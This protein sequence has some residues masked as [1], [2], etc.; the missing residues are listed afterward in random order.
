MKRIFTT[1]AFVLS[2]MVAFSQ[3]YIIPSVNA[4]K[5]P[6]GINNDDEQ[7]YAWLSA[8]LTGYSQLL[9]SS[10]T[11]AWSSNQTIPFTFKFNGVTETQFKVSNTGVLTFTTSA[12][13]APSSTN[14]ALPSA[15]IP[16]KSVCAWGLNCGGS[17]DGVVMKTFGTSPNRQLWVIWASASESG[18][19]TG[20]QWTYWGIVLEETTN[21]IHVVDMRTYSA[22]SGNVTLTAGVQINSSSAISVSGS[23]NLGSTNTASGGSVVDASDNSYWTFVQGT[24]PQ[25]DMSATAESMSQYLVLGQAPFSIKGTL[26]NYGTSTITS[27]DLNYSVNGGSAVTA[28]AT[29]SPNVASYATY[30]FTHP[31]G[32][33]PS[34]A[35]TYTIDIWASNLNGNADQNTSNDKLTFQVEVVDTM[36]NRRT[37]LEVFTSSTC[38]PCAGGNAN[39]DNNVLPTIKDFAVVKYQQNFPG[40]GDPYQTTESVNRRGYYA[41]NSIPRME[42][43]GQWDGNAGAFTKSIFNY[44]QSQPAFLNFTF[45]KA[46]YTGSNVTIDYDVNPVKDINS[47]SY[48]VQT[49]II[50]KKTTG[51][52]ATNGETE[53]HNVMMDMIPNENGSSIGPFTKGNTVNITKSSN[54]STSNVEQ[55][56]D[57]KLVVWVEDITTKTVL[58]CDWTDIYLTGNVGPLGITTIDEKGNGI[59]NIYPNPVVNQA[60]LKYQVAD[61]SNE[62][63]INIV[64]TIGQVVQSNVIADAQSGVNYYQINTESMENGMYLVN[65]TIGSKSFTK[66]LV[67]SK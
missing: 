6:G 25:Y 27:M 56:S 55:M 32:W 63:R 57:L 9:G 62:V 16:D 39:M 23:P 65:L 50:E 22:S 8:N 10:A 42:I 21:N 48:K 11:P 3:Y 15:S 66:R 13:T 17:N 49:V 52:V 5:N 58:N 31:T 33:T 34:A 1:L 19:G 38:G 26:T 35:G 4:G 24:Q 7:P 20:S 43:D 37:L 12:A 64:N 41:I 14:A 45:N 59:V 67:V 2:G 54:L 36:V 46:E 51:N 28:A 53:F 40:S 30:N 60:R 47:G 18:L 44:Y 29:G 61:N